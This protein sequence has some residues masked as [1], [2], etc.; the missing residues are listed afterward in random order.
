[1]DESI[2]E[3]LQSVKGYLGGAINNYTGE[4]L[5]CDAQR[6]SGNLEETSA[7]FND[8]FRES[9]KVSKNLKLGTTKVMEIETENG[10]VLMGCSGEDARVHLHIFAI[11]SNDGNI[12]L[13]KMALKKILPQAVDSLS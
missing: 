6:L 3:G 2:M 4:C 12:A 8:I 7:T 5:I 1:M 9:H 10:R 11:F 13:G